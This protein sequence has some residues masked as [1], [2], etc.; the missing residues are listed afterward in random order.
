MKIPFLFLLCTA[1]AS[2]EKFKQVDLVKLSD[3]ALVEKE[4]CRLTNTDKIHDLT[5]YRF[6]KASQADGKAP[7]FV[8][9][10]EKNYSSSYISPYEYQVENPEELFKTGKTHIF[11]HLEPSIDLITSSVLMIFDE[12]GEEIRPFGGNNYID[13]GYIY[14]FNGDGILDRADYTNYGLKKAKG[15]EVQVFELESIEPTPRELLKVIF[16]WHPDSVADANRWTYECFDENG[17]G[18]P[19]I[20]FGPESAATEEARREIVFRFDKASG[21]YSA[22][23]LPEKPHLL[24]MKS[25]DTLEA[26]ADAGGLGYPL[27]DPEKT[28]KN[29]PLSPQPAQ[30]YVY[31]SLKNRPIEELAAFFQGKN[32]R[33]AFDGAEGSF[34]NVLPENFSKKSPKDAALAIAEANRTPQHRARYQLA[35]DD[36]KIFP[37]TSGWVNYAWDSSGCY[38]SSS[39]F[40]AIH[41]GVPEPVL[42]VYGDNNIGVVGRNRWADQ[43]AHNARLIR[44]AEKEARFLA[45]TIFWLNRIRSRTLPGSKE[46]NSFGGSTADGYASVNLFPDDAPPHLLASGTAWAT[47]SISGSWDG[48]YEHSTFV[49]LAGLL[50]KNG[51]QEMLGKRWETTGEITP[52]SLVTPTDERLAPR[53]D[54]SER[55]QLSE[56]FSRI[57]KMNSEQAIPADI[58]NPLCEAAG[59]EALVSLLPALEK[60]HASLPAADDDEAEY[61]VLRRRFA[62]DHFGEPLADEPAEHKQDYARMETLRDKLRYHPAHVLRQPLESAITRLRLASDPARLQQAIIDNAPEKSWALTLL[63][64]T[65]PA[66]WAILVSEDFQKVKDEDRREILSTIAAGHPP[67]A[68]EMIRN[69]APEE[70]PG[71]ILEIAS[72]HKE[73]SPADLSGDV[74]AILEIVRDRKADFYR[75][76]EA[77]GFLAG[78][79]LSPEQ[80]TK[81]RTLLVSEI[82]NPVKGKET[83]MGST[84]GTAA[85]ALGELPNPEQQLQLF[86]DTPEI[87]KGDFGSGFNTLMKMTRDNPD[88]EKI[89]IDFVRPQFTESRR[90]MNWIFVKALAQNLRGLAPDL[91]AFASSGPE[92]QDGDGANYSGGNFKSP[93]GQRYHIA[94]EI[95][96]LWTE[97]DPVT[98]AK[99]W[100]AF[101]S[102]HPDD[103]DTESRNQEI[104]APLRKLAEKHILVLSKK[105]RKKIMESLTTEIP[106]SEYYPGTSR[107]LVSL[108]E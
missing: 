25:D 96:A 81:F 36:N 94:R 14:D 103:F 61:A 78:I 26:I 38:S 3:P 15:K 7:L 80:L 60:L 40:Y 48:V 59:S 63:R 102:A 19:E 89:L 37:P 33:N 88:R 72:F 28:L 55:E 108:E 18:I 31:E 79:S 92:V 76:N 50:T 41:F 24:V 97:K 21:E 77:I 90:M 49:N 101:A 66:T 9:T 45:D 16:N 107:W 62:R 104:A 8:L 74:P 5:E 67:T 95:T 64:R 17:D 58:L 82:K 32:R 75:R 13:R 35:I 56:I 105:E 57:L 39:E 27:L 12:K 4:V 54:D 53:V 34:P 83:W 85:D 10:A 42:I 20:A 51:I 6:L 73:H 47:T 30:A 99:M 91:A 71:L 46:R 98:L 65:D 69:L 52:H 2:A 23:E 84:R 1:A 106:A 86:L 70:K 100:I 11:A 93:V 87:G 43:P 68:A 29:P 22:G 44:L